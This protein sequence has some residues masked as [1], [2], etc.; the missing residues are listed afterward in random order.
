MS[1]SELRRLQRILNDLRPTRTGVFCPIDFGDRDL[2]VF[3]YPSHDR[4]E[5]SVR[6]SGCR[7]ATNGRRT[8]STNDR[9]RGTLRT[10]VD[11]PTS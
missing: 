11:G 3:A 2:L 10:L 4:V 7:F 5:V 6:L 9:V 8:V 1:G